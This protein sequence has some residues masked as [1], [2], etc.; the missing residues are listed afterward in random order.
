MDTS[1]STPF[2]SLEDLRRENDRLLE[3][4]P[5]DESKLSQQ[6]LDA[7]AAEIQKFLARAVA[8]GAVLDSPAERRMAQG[9]IDYWVA[10]SYTTQRDR[11]AK[12]RSAT[13]RTVGLKDFE[14][15]RAT[16]AARRGT[17]YVEGIEALETDRDLVLDL[18]DRVMNYFFRYQQKDYDIA[19]RLLLRVIRLSETGGEPVSSP[20]PLKTLLSLG[21]PSRVQKILN[22]L[23]GTDVLAIDQTDD[24]PLV[25]L[26]YHSLIQNWP[27]LRKLIEERM[28]FRNRALAWVKSKR[29]V[30]AL[31][32]GKTAKE[33]RRYANLNEIEQDFA[34]A[35][36]A[37]AGRLAAL[38]VA[39]TSTLTLIVLLLFS[40]PYLR[41]R[42]YLTPERV[43][44]NLTIIVKKAADDYNR[45]RAKE[46]QTS[47]KW[48]S[49]NKRE[50]KV[51][52]ATLRWMNLAGLY[53]QR[54]DFTSAKLDVVGLNQA[55]LRD[56]SFR[57][58][59][60]SYVDFTGADL[61]GAAFSEAII[62]NTDFNGASL[63]RANFD[64]VRFCGGVDFSNA[65]VRK[66]SAKNV[67]FSFVPKLDGTAWWLMDG[68][69]VQQR[70]TLGT[71][72]YNRNELLPSLRNELK[73]TQQVLTKL[74]SET[75]D[76]K[77]SLAL[78]LNDNAWLLATY[79][80]DSRTVRIDGKE[81]NT[82]A[83][84]QARLAIAIMQDLMKTGDGN[85]DY[86]GNK[87]NFGDTLGYIL[88][89]Q[90]ARADEDK[91][92]VTRDKLL[93]EAKA[94]FEEAKDLSNDAGVI[95]RY[96]VALNALGEEQDAADNLAE[97]MEEQDYTPTHELYLLKRF[98]TGRSGPFLSKWKEI[99][100]DDEEE[101]PGA[102]SSKA[103]PCASSGRR[104]ELPG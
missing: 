93:N 16:E 3:R 24:D 39:G 23:V 27:W 49:D 69:T 45:E 98:I 85:R 90:A 55:N 67:T 32:G 41:E 61:G 15:R 73:E 12:G 80:F 18:K 50:I 94:L 65:D 36:E 1:D 44:D 59:K 71:K 38:V 56:S 101:P 20:T 10:S 34:N 6:E 75:K 68:L 86:Q 70:N 97:A 84:A 88:L 13:R 64:G 103:D 79:G 29:S 102:E 47:I 53:G 14:T 22:G 35:S 37:L 99:T 30:L 46:I 96:A 5:D 58:G 63:I 78:W 95:F 81:V 4:Q 25:S 9:L 11:T 7:N 42:Y 21:D 2:S 82:N 92:G 74:L 26:K 52:T 43:Q 60:L 17:E 104:T 31:L 48:L 40:N 28:Y 83:E 66:A 19:R 8:T 91:D 76:N 51:A 87:A 89:Q 72:P 33:F 57:K 77:F 100:D 62:A 54:A